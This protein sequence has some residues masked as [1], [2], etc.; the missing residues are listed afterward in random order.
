[1][2]RF[3]PQQVWDMYRA[4]PGQDMYDYSP[5]LREAARGCVV[6]IGVRDGVST[7]A[8]LLGLAENGGHLWSI[9]TDD[10][11]ADLF[12][13]PNWT[14]VHGY[15]T[16]VRLYQEYGCCSEIDILLIDGDHSYDGLTADLNRFYPLMKPGGTILCHDVQPLDP[17]LVADWYDVEGCHR[18]WRDFTADKRNAYVLP[19]LTGMGVIRKDE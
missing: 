8:L 15:S 9:D 10:R 3:T 7:A 1:M 14:F 16:E 6:E 19:G 18:A 5:T 2:A 17:T 12:D 13:D 4:M 11:C